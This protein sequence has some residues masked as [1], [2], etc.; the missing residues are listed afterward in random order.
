M[1]RRSQGSVL[2]SIETL[3]SVGSL[4]GLTDAELLEQFLSRHPESAEAAFSALVALHGPMVWNVCRAVLC[5][6]HAAEDAFQATFLVLV[7]KPHSI[8]RRHSVGPWLYGVARRI[9]MRARADARRRWRSEGQVADM[10]SVPA[11]APE[12]WE[13]IQFLHQELDKLP[14][15]YRAPVVLCGLEGRTHSEAARLLNCPVSTV[16]IRLSRARERLRMRLSRR[17]LA[18]PA[19][20]AGA[21]VTARTAF[22][23]MPVGLAE[24]T[25]HAAA[26]LAANPLTATGSLSA[27]ITE[28]AKGELRTMVFTRFKV[29]AFGIVMAGFVATAVGFLAAAE[30]PPQRNPRVLVAAA[31]EQEKADEPMARQATMNNLKALGLAMHN[32]AFRHDNRLPPAAISPFGEPLLSWRV[33][34][35]PYLDQ[36]ALYRKFHLDEPWDSPHNKELLKEMPQVYAPV[37]HGDRAKNS[38][39]YQVFVGPGTLF[40]GSRGTRFADV[41]D[42]TSN[43][44]LVVEGAEP[45]PW[46]KPEDVAI[47]NGKPLPKLGGLFDDGFHVDLGDGAALFLNKK[48]DPET[49]RA[50]ITRSGGEVID[51][52][53]VNPAK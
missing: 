45:V 15:K 34:I 26:Q 24:R 10:T 1:T 7:R 20:L 47:E 30:K 13:A 4:A 28:L 8:R 16:S 25:V 38:T 37:T 40:D 11:P 48:I 21:T 39:Y 14:E 43:T 31:P 17:G 12:E 9:A 53:K 41:Q 2:R 44:I 18:L 23:A 52:N 50:L 6:A 27:S 51:F 46:T 22:A 29:A 35:L 3:F 42:G 49:L 19:A 5:D 32:F 33:A 36:E